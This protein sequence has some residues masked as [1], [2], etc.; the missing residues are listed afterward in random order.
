ME[1]RVKQFERCIL[2]EN[3]QNAKSVQSCMDFTFC[4]F[5]K[6]IIAKYNYHMHKLKEVYF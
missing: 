3:D 6:I 2:A 5:P 1:L 4:T